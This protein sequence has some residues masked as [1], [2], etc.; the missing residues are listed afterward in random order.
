MPHTFL[1]IR[2]PLVNKTEKNNLHFGL[3]RVVKI[4]KKKY[5]FN[6]IVVKEKIK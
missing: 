1:C 4:I 3:V 6:I 5:Y 2:N